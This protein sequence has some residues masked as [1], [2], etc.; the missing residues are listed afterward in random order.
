M[1]AAGLDGIKNKIKAP[2]PLTKI[3]TLNEKER[4]EHGIITY[5]LLLLMHRMTKS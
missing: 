1:L 5:Q 4:E 2:Q 3:Y